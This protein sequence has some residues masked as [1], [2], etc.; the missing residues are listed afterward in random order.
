LVGRPE[1]NRPLQRPGC[2]SYDIKMDITEIGGGR[3]EWFTP[4]SDRNK[5]RAFVITMMN[6]W[7]PLSMKSSVLNGRLSEFARI[8]WLCGLGLILIEVLLFFFF[9]V[10]SC[11]MPST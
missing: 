11:Y 2:R 8:A 7:F 4:D 3:L 5:W 9:N 6:P 10:C 1:G